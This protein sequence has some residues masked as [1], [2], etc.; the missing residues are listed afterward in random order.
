[1]ET[2]DPLRLR[3]VCRLVPAGLRVDSRSNGQGSPS[4]RCLRLDWEYPAP[5]AR[6]D[7]D[8]SSVTPAFGEPVETK[9]ARYV[10]A[11]NGFRIVYETP[12]EPPQ[13]RAKLGS[14]VYTVICNF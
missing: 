14:S 8:A 5:H 6:Q 9:K 7:V 4:L 2:I 11:L 13:A 3:P 1:M 10:V 12:E